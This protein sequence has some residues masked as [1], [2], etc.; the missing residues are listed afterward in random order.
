MESAKKKMQKWVSKIFREFAPDNEAP[1]AQSLRPE[2][3]D[4]AI[5]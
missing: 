2:G 5:Y 3:P 4:A 1:D